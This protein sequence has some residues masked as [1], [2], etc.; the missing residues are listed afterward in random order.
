MALGGC[1]AFET[2]F[3]VQYNDEVVSYQLSIVRQFMKLGAAYETRDS[4][5]IFAALQ[6]V[7]DTAQWARQQIRQMPPYDGD[8]SL[9]LAAQPLFD[10]YVKLVTQ[11]F[12]V[13]ARINALPD[14]AIT[15]AHLETLAEIEQRIQRE[16]EPI[17]KA[18]AAAQD[19]F[20]HDYGF[21]VQRQSIEDI[22]E[23]GGYLE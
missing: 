12:P 6:M 4:A 21:Q 1:R 15:D 3:A 14:E 22:Q 13:V 18:F 5:Q 8:S 10:F 7:Q 11:D 2:R 19:Q 23:Q 9:Y 20:A 17:D 16:E